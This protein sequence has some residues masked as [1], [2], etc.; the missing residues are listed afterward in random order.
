M[1]RAVYLASTQ[2]QL[3]V[4]YLLIFVVSI[5]S[6]VLALAEPL[7]ILCTLSSELHWIPIAIS[8]ALGQTTGFALL[9]LFGDRILNVLPSLKRRLDQ[10][11]LSRYEKTKDKITLAGALFGMPPMTVLAAAGPVYEPKAIRFLGVA[12]GGRLLR[13]LVIAGAPALFMSVFDPELLP[14]WT[15]EMFS[16]PSSPSE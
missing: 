4:F 8:V 2:G 11:D 14:E 13:F 5:V 6:P 15:R 3:T 9:Y 7:T 12:F 1:L 16:L 10:L